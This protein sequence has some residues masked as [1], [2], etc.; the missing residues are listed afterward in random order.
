ME[1]VLSLFP[2]IDLLGRGFEEE[3][4]TVVRGP[5]PVFGGDIRNFHPTPG[6]FEG[7]IGGPPCQAFSRLNYLHAHDK[8]FKPA[9]NLI[10]EFERCV[11]EAQPEWFIMENVEGAPL[12]VVKGYTIHSQM[13]NNREHG[14]G[15]Q[16]RRR[17]ISFGTRN[18]KRL[19]VPEVTPPEEY[20]P[21]VLA[22]G[23]LKPGTPTN[24]TP[25][26][27]ELGW[28]T[29]AALTEAI[30]LQGLPEDFKLPQFSVAGA[31]K[32]VGNGVPI[33]LGRAIARGVRRSL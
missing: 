13:L 7:I 32:V 25:K 33:P 12:P 3:G 21:T 2:G 29:K 18:G 14:G 17:R 6:K 22:S 27:N 19:V 26:K 16:N 24:R 8:N 4:F 15:I 9:E 31:I 10:P 30:R 23:G 11:L 28:K 20:A 1:L 5:D